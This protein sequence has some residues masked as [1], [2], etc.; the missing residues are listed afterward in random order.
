MIVESLKDYGCEIDGIASIFCIYFG[1][2]PR[3]Y[4]DALRLDKEKYLRFYWKLLKKGVFIPPSQYEVCFISVAHS[5][6]DISRS[7]DAMIE[8]LKEL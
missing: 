8:C 1:K 2:K 5:D 3:N 4:A 7:V 6:E